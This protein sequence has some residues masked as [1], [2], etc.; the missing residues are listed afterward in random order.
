MNCF[1]CGE[2]GH[3]MRDCWHCDELEKSGNVAANNG[4]DFKNGGQFHGNGVDD[5]S[6]FSMIGNDVGI[7][8]PTHKSFGLND[9]GPPPQSLG[10]MS[11]STQN[12][13]TMTTVDV[14]AE[15]AN[16]GRNPNSVDDAVMGSETESETK[17]ET[18]SEP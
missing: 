8:A 9:G 4:A 10:N 15:P 5:F 17:S 2:C 13:Q 14:I 16:D 3:V 12:L 1:H 7:P 18:R 6:N 11:Q